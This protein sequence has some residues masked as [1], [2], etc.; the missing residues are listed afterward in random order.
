MGDL[1]V[2]IPGEKPEAEEETVEEVIDEGV[3][4]DEPVIEELKEKVKRFKDPFEDLKDGRL[5]RM[6]LK[7]PQL[8]MLIYERLG[9]VGMVLEDIR[10]ELSRRP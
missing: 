1:E 6:W 8:L 3:V 2:P 4:L 5:R 7:E 9:S 10:D